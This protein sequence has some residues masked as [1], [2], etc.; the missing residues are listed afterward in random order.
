MAP[1]TVVTA[2]MLTKLWVAIDIVDAT[3]DGWA[4]AFE[5]LRFAL[6]GVRFAA[7]YFPESEEVGGRRALAA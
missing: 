7:M 5:L 1:E 4:L 6:G 3:C 2:T